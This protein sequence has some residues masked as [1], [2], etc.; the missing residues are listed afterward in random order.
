MS[1]PSTSNELTSLD[2]VPLV[3]IETIAE[4][5]NA[6]SITEFSTGRK[7][8]SLY[9]IL[10]NDKD[11]IIKVMAKDKYSSNEV[12]RLS[13]LQHP[14]I[15]PFHSYKEHDQYIFLATEYIQGNNLSQLLK[16]KHRLEE[17]EIGRIFSQM[18]DVISYLHKEKKLVHRDLKL[19]NIHYSP[20]HQTI[21]LLDFEFCTEYSQEFLDHQVGTYEYT[22]PEFRKKEYR[23]PEN[24]IWALGIILYALA[25]G[26]L[27]FNSFQLKSFMEKKAFRFPED[28]ELT[29]TFKDLVYKILISEPRPNITRILKHNWTLNY[30]PRLGTFKK[31]RTNFFRRRTSISSSTPL[32]TT[33]QSISSLKVTQSQLKSNLRTISVGKNAPN[34]MF[35]SMRTFSESKD[36]QKY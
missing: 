5:F 19:E 22:S 8:R 21:Y 3:S 17:H 15:I 7:N 31:I 16:Q 29:P 9:R 1:S 32:Q 23:G 10:T 28:V 12:H 2:Q 20:V 18:V 11:L 27:P 24:D 4:H 36:T 13:S 33:R 26:S 25:C 14:N 35:S 30:L 6:K 34:L